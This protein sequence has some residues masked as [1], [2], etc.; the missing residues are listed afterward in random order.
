[1][2]CIARLQRFNSGL[3][4]LTQ[5]VALGYFISRR[6]RLNLNEKCEMKYRQCSLRFYLS[7]SRMYLI[8]RTNGLLLA[9]ELANAFSVSPNL[10]ARTRPSAAH[11]GS[12]GRSAAQRISDPLSRRASIP[13][14]RRRP[15][16]STPE[17]VR[18]H[19]APRRSAPG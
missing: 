10:I 16:R 7:A 17:P 4:P 1:M 8:F 2:N 9:L 15:S 14:A 12:V 19:P 6:W 13:L 5:G 18:Y 3:N 11:P